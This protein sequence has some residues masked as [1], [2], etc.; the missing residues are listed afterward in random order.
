MTHDAAQHAQE[1]VLARL[2][3]AA[4]RRFRLD[5]SVSV[6]QSEMLA[7]DAIRGTEFASAPGLTQGAVHSGVLDGLSR[8]R[9][10]TGCPSCVGRR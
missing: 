6:T 2:P 10:T 9:W 5:A 1:V 7:P 8:W 3:S 4:D